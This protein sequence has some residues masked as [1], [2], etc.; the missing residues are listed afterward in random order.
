MSN[1]TDTK[2]F[3]Q[4]C[5]LK[6][7][8]SYNYNIFN[9]LNRCVNSEEYL[10]ST[11]DKLLNNNNKKSTDINLG[12][13]M[14]ILRE[15]SYGERDKLCQ[16]IIKSLNSATESFRE[17][18]QKLLNDEK[19]TN[20]E[21]ISMYNNY[22]QN[23]YNIRSLLHN[24]QE[25][26]ETEI[27][28]YKNI[29]IVYSKY[30]FYYNVI[31]RQY[32]FGNDNLFLYNLFLRQWDKKNVLDFFELL[33]IS[34]YFNMF[35]KKIFENHATDNN[36]REKFFNVELESIMVNFDETKT[37]H[38]LIE[39][40]NVINNKIMELNKRMQERNNVKEG[41]IK[42][43]ISK[44]YNYVGRGIQIC[45]KVQFMVNYYTNLKGRLEEGSRFELERQ[46]QDVISAQ[47]H[48]ELYVKMQFC[49]NDMEDSSILTS[50]IHDLPVKNIIFASQKYTGTTC[51]MFNKNIC[52]YFIY[53][54][55]AWSQ[56]NDMGTVNLPPQLSYY[57]DIFINFPEIKN[58]DKNPSL[59]HKKISVDYEKSIVNLSLKFNEK[60]YN[61]K[62]N[63]LQAA[64]LLTIIKKKSIS[65]KQIIEELCISHIKFISIP[66]NSLL[67][68]GLILRPKGISPNDQNYVFS[69]NSNWNPDET[70]IDLVLQSRKIKE[71]ISNMKTG[72]PQV[73]SLT[74]EEEVKL[75]ADIIKYLSDGKKSVPIEKI[76]EDVKN[77]SENLLQSILNSLVE[78]N[79]LTKKNNLYSCNEI[80]DSDS[81]SDIE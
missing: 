67:F 1:I 21:F 58:P 44:I 24:C 33:E 25:V 32:K 75:K 5:R 23:V 79:V 50:K 26:F 6:T 17:K 51:D 30:L 49:I 28:S 20:G 56:K 45:D 34:D 41:E 43:L 57:I 7:F 78:K 47:N 76:I 61:I 40:M 46:I 36:P 27:D 69:I 12:I 68:V 8:E 4:F 18:V 48:K 55:N 14:H 13:C 11:F 39:L 80:T 16:I 71:K 38:F 59:K 66:L 19:Y 74:H 22:N 77:I 35:S 3:E 81:D 10:A 54:H 60:K 37:D 63:I 9:G 64:I 42:R 52:K 62:A 70:N 31:N 15:M 72:Q 2:F 29:V 53:R 73:V 65:L